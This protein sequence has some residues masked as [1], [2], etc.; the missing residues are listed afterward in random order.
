MSKIR[1]FLT[2]SLLTALLVGLYAPK[3]HAQVV[4]TLDTGYDPSGFYVMEGLGPQSGSEE[5]A[6]TV[7]GGFDAL[8]LSTNGGGVSYT[9]DSI[10]IQPQGTPILAVS[11]SITLE[12]F[13]AE[14]GAYVDVDVY[15]YDQEG[16]DSY[17]V[18]SMTPGQT[19]DVG[20]MTD[21]V[22]GLGTI[23]I[24]QIGGFW[25]ETPKMLTLTNLSIAYGLIPGQGYQLA[26][27]SDSESIVPANYAAFGGPLGP[28][29]SGGGGGPVPELP[30]GASPLFM[31]ALGYALYKLR[32]LRPAR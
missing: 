24:M 22:D 20:I 18:Y 29:G 31:S 23:S 9:A 14:G 32:A 16:Y 8:Q 26:D 5:I 7:T 27:Y 17:T 12:N 6:A 25:N 28:V 3:L 13:D 19:I 2:V 10:G 21:S 15:A 11:M 1:V 30:P 4:T